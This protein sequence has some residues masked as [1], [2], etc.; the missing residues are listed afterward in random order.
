MSPPGLSEIVGEAA[1]AHARLAGLSL[2][3]RLARAAECRRRLEDRGEEIVD[4]AVAEVGQAVRFARRELRS[5]LLFLDA[6]PDLAAAIRP[7]RVPA[8]SGTT[9]LEWAPYG[10]VLGWHAANSP[11]WVPTVVAVSALVAGNAVISRPSRRARRTT[12]RVLDALA[13]PWPPGALQVVDAP[14]EE[15]EWLV[16]APGVDAVVAHASTATC[17]RHL[18]R[19]GEAYAAGARLRPY[20]A[21]ASGNDA[22]LVLAGADLDRAAEA[23]ALAGFANSGQLCM[24]AKRLIVERSVW[25]GFRPR[26]VRAVEGLVLGDPGHERTDIAPLAEGPARA[27]ARQALAEALALGGEI[28]VG[29]GERGPFFTPT[30]VLLPRRA[31]DAML[32]RDEVFA[33]LRA[34]VLAEDAADAVALA[35]DTSFGLGASVFGGPP[36]VVAGLRAARVV[37][38]ETPLYQDPNLVVGGIRDSGFGGARPKLEQLVYARRVHRADLSSAP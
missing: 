24:A 6:L 36:E 14:P 7:R 10:V 21:E 35:N 15:A 20:V 13:G 11:V 4:S 22:L 16:S 30:V 1:R 5:A 23:A 25:E 31:L 26:L 34:L 29:A 32:W 38:E 17:R 2:D 12:G 28:V 9:V 18:A 3:A 37:V 8:V 27:H 19:L 33:P